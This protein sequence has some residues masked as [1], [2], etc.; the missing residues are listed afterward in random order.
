MNSLQQYD[1]KSLIGIGLI[2]L[3]AMLRFYGFW[4]WSLT[5]DELST[6]FRSQYNG[7]WEVVE[8]GVKPDVH[9]AFVEVFMHYWGQLFGHSVFVY[10]LPFV[11]F[12]IG[13]LVYFYRLSTLWLNR[14]AALVGT[15]IIVSSQLFVLYAQIARAYSVGLFFILLFTFHWLKVIQDKHSIKDII[16][17]MLSGALTLYT[18]YFTGLSTFLLLFLG[19]FLVKKQRRLYYLFYAIGVGIL[20][21]PHLSITLDHL[22]KGGVGW[23][24]EPK[25]DFI[26]D[27]LHFTFNASPLFY[28]SLLIIPIVAITSNTL[29]LPSKKQW[30]IFS[31]FA[32]PYLIAFFYS[33]HRSPVLQF[34]VLI[35]CTPFLILTIA[36]FISEQ[37]KSNRLYATIAFLLFTGLFS[38]IVQQSFYSK[39]RFANFK[40]VAELSVKWT[41]EVGKDKTLTIANTNNPYYLN[42]YTSKIDSSFFYDVPNFDDSRKI[43]ST[44]DLIQNSDAEYILTAFG[45]LAVPAEIHEYIKNN[46]VP[47]KN[48]KRFFNSEVILY[49]RAQVNRPISFQTNA[50]KA[51]SS[52]KWNIDKN[53]LQTQIF[54]SDSI[55]FMMRKETEYALTYKDTVK[56]LFTN[57]S[58]YF[59]LSAQLKHA[60]E[61]NLILSVSIERNGENVY[62]RGVNTNDYIT[63]NNWNEIIHVIERTET[64]ED[65]DL[66]TIFFWNKDH[67]EA[68]IDDFKIINFENSDYNYYLF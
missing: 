60:K 66:V 33:I 23:L 43:A 25:N 30:I 55:A 53:A 9:P 40:E 13:A 34:S 50:I 42:F 4:D 41:N 63:T 51:L 21:V 6:L 10:R 31:L 35:F 36:S 26:L 32:C 16:I 46:F 39:K 19:L 3:G 18:H 59:V 15:A 65:N 8:K 11:L 7:F 54:Y 2:I 22:E 44:R 61:A 28:Y 12:S 20:F 17:M 56:N 14:N 68:Y 27:F 24:P 52:T 48:N 47:T 49:K 64:I 1:T 5:N 67:H 45:N 58:N 62:W 37:L 38:L 57:S 29:K